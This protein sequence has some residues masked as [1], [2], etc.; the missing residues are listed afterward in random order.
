MSETFELAARGDAL[1]PGWFLYLASTPAVRLWSGVANF[2]LGAG[3]GPDAAGGIYFGLG[4]LPQ[5]PDLPI[6]LNGEFVTFEA[7][8][9]G[10]TPKI[11]ALMK[12][13]APAVRQARISFGTIE[14]DADSNPIGDIAW[15]LTCW[16]DTPRM[17]RD[18]ARKPPLLNVSLVC[19]SGSPRR[20]VTNGGAWTGVQQRIIDANDS[21]CDRVSQMATGTDEIWPIWTTGEHSRRVT[22][23]DERANSAGRRGRAPGTDSP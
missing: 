4:I 11:A 6:P 17:T 21:S 18:G 3:Q 19:S 10:V 15:P 22:M 8:L 5:I 2:K 14:L 7:R 9:S 23:V 12:Q 20:T 13:D 1:R 16:V